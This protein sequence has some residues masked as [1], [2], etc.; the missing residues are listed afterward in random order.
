MEKSR[1]EPTIFFNENISFSF[2]LF[3]GHFY[4]HSF[5]KT[6][7]GPFEL[8]NYLIANLTVAWLYNL[9]FLARKMHFDNTERSTL[10]AVVS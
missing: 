8:M 3:S 6:V 5:I 9:I 4:G 1:V 10:W 7:R 2:K